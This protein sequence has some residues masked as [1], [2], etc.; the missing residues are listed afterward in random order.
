M[1]PEQIEIL[2]TARHLI[3][4]G[5]TQG[6]YARNAIG[7]RTDPAA[8][9]AVCW[10]TLGA[11]RRASGFGIALNHL[12]YCMEEDR[13]RIE[14]NYGVVTRRLIDCIPSHQGYTAGELVSFNDAANR[15]K[16]DVLKLFDDA[17]QG[18][19]V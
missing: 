18:V 13:Y 17:I 15:T 12:V 1:T 8:E 3:E 14:T 5:W 19:S 9:N 4:Q 7:D 11:L 16:A 2:K 6:N 10:C